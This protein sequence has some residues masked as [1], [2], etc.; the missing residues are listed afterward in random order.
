MRKSFFTPFVVFAVLALPTHAAPAGTVAD[1]AWMTGSWA[2]AVGPQTL[3]ENWIQPTGSSIASLVRMTGR[4]ATSMIELIVIEEEGDS[5]VLRIQQ[6]NPGFVPR[7]PEPQTMELIELG[8]N[9][10]AFRAI[11]PGGMKTLAYSSPDPDS[12][13]IDIEN[14]QGAKFQLN[15]Q[16][17]R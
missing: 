6:W 13:N 8:K 1:L 17:R 11:S 7:T 16:A 5:L 10:V 2:G 3:E 15:L 9:S 4:G 14:A 12:F